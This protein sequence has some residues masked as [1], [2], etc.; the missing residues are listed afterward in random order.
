MLQMPPNVIVKFLGFL[1]DG[2]VRRSG[3]RTGFSSVAGF[4]FAVIDSSMF[5]VCSIAWKELPISTS[6]VYFFQRMDC[7]GLWISP[8]GPNAY[9]SHFILPLCH[10][11]EQVVTSGLCIDML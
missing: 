1:M 8:W 7:G 6:A 3:N 4:W 11:I 5:D 9:P 2:P 10:L